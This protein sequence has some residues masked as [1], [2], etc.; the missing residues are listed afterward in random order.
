MS[1]DMHLPVNPVD[2]VTKP[3]LSSHSKLVS[4]FY[5]LE[6]SRK[7]PGYNGL[8]QKKQTIVMLLYDDL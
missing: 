6:S 1:D 4:R 5:L 8:L 7:I 3:V 2:M